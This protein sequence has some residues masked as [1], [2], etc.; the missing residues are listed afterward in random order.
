MVQTIPEELFFE[1]SAKGRLQHFSENNVFLHRGADAAK[2]CFKPCSFDL[3]SDP[4][5]ASA[6][7]SAELGR[8]IIVSKNVKT[9]IEQLSCMYAQ[10]RSDSLPASNTATVV[11]T[12][13]RHLLNVGTNTNRYKSFD[14]CTLKHS[15]SFNP[16]KKSVDTGKQV[17]QRLLDET[18]VQSA[19]KSVSYFLEIKT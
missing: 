19:S 7:V 18:P 2:H 1:L 3:Q 8:E 11:P 15:Y 13:R 17:T 6:T 4:Q 16:L 12:N 5:L 9:R 10:P 14:T